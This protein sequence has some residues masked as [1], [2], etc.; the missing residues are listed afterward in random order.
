MENLRCCQKWISLFW[1]NQSNTIFDLRYQ[2]YFDSKSDFR[3]F[4]Y[5][6][7]YKKKSGDTYSGYWH[8][9]KLIINV[10]HVESIDG[11]KVT[12]LADLG[13]LKDGKHKVLFKNN[14]V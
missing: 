14:L 2:G 10:D 9:G 12:N 3:G 1:T 8:K 7:E 5:L 4:H 11:K 6:G 13:V